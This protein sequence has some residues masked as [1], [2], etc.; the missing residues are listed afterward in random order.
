MVLK[1]KF[2]RTFVRHISIINASLSINIASLSA[3]GVDL[4]LS[5]SVGLCVC[6]LVC[7]LVRKVYCGKTA[8]W[9]RMPFGM[10]SGVCRGMDVLDGDGD[11]QRRGAV[12]WMNLG[13]P[14]VTNGNFGAQCVVTVSYTHLRATR[15]Y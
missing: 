7:L 6:Q 12:L 5:P 14:I 15:P 4:S 3:S 1:F 10:V 11:R 2:K 8:D 13:C 9:I